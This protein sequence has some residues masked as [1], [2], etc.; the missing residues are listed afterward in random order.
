LIYVDVAV[1][2]CILGGVLTDI[3]TECKAEVRDMLIYE[4]DEKAFVKGIREEG[5]EDGLAEGRSAG[6]AEGCSV[7]LAEGQFNTLASLVRDGIISD[8]EAAS[9]LGMSLPEFEKKL[10][11]TTI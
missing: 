2:E 1:D 10:C 11:E 3:L 6:L 4:F 9:R 8:N 7:G 5:F